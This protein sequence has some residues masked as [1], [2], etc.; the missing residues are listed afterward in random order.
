M[1]FLIYSHFHQR[2]LTLISVQ[3]LEL[4]K[5]EKQ[6]ERRLKLI[7]IETGINLYSFFELCVW[8]NLNT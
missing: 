6:A 3:F 8:K 7:Y 2:R 4:K 1:Y 5:D